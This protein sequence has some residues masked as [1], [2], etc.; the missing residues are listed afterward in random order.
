MIFEK[1]CRDLNEHNT[2][3]LDEVI[4]LLRKFSNNGDSEQR[5]LLQIA[6]LIVCDL[7]KDKKNRNHCDRF[8]DIL[9]EIIA[10]ASK[11]TDNMD[12]LMSVTLP[13]FIIIVKS[14]VDAQKNATTLDT[15][16]STEIPKLMKTYLKNTVITYCKNL[17]ILIFE[18]HLIE[19][20]FRSIQEISF[21]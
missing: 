3:V 20:M 14:H 1:T 15:K 4:A 7:S 2:N 11:Q 5:I 21:R 17:L 16:N 12:W 18:K 13:A 19:I 10:N 8:R 6:V 9:F